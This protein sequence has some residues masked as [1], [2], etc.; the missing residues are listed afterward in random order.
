MNRMN[1]EIKQVNYLD[2]ELEIGPG[3]GRKF[4]VTVIRSPAGE[5]QET[6]NFPFDHL[7]LENRLKDLQIALLRSGGKHRRLNLPEQQTVQDFGKDLFKAL[8]CGETRSRYDVS[9]NKAIQQGKGLRLKIRVQSP[10]LTA[11]PWEYIFDERQGEYLCLSRKTPVVRYIE[12]PQAIQ[13]ID[14]KLP[15]RILGM[16]SSPID[17]PSLDVEREKQRIEQAIINLRKKGLVELTWLQGQTWRELQGAMR[18]GP[19]HI[20]HFIGHGGFDIERDEGIICL[21]DEKGKRD[22]MSA[23]QLGRLLADHDSLRLVLLN[24]C[25]GARSGDRDIFSSSASILVQRGIPAVI[26]MQY[27]V[28]DRAAIEFARSFY[29]ALTDGLPIDASVAEAR[30]AISLAVDNTLE[31]GTPVLYMRSPDGVLFSLANKPEEKKLDPEIKKEPPKAPIPKEE[32]PLLNISDSKEAPQDQKI[33]RE[34]GKRPLRLKWVLL[35]ASIVAVV[36]LAISFKDYFMGKPFENPDKVEEKKPT[37]KNKLI[38]EENVSDEKNSLD[39]KI[40]IDEKMPADVRALLE[41]KKSQVKK[42][43]KNEKG[44][45][46]A[47]FGDGII[48]VYIPAGKFTMGANDGNSAEKPVREV[49]VDGYW[50]GKY[51]VTFA[52]YD[53]FCNLTEKRKPD[54]KGWSRGKRPVIHVNWND[55]SEYCEWLSQKTGLE[56]KLPTEAQWEKAARGKYGRKYPWG[57][58]P[59]TGKELNFADKQEWLKEKDHFAARDID[60]GFAY[61]APVDSFPSGSSPYGLMDMVGNVWEW[62]LDWYKEDFYNEG[63]D[64]NPQGPVKGSHRVIRGGSWGNSAASCR[65]SHRRGRLPVDRWRR[66][67]FRLA[68]S[69]KPLITLPL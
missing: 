51:E 15:L 18:H 45:W 43:H 25:E 32:S 9:L 47:D 56:F 37:D 11:L 26:A 68:G 52:Q 42:V 10:E 55:A 64:G 66:I 27:E 44:F 54:D 30:K 33:A 22:H 31:W 58:S 63:V 2:Y 6:M 50:I 16:I 12:L 28:T 53:E 1:D 39:K 60:D 49:Y 8:I 38:G 24:S 17:L 21:S 35:A 61:T 29:E 48:M 36:A 5:A 41:N 13:P 46:E 20:F 65:A 19:W 3:E 69:L 4:P 23:S 7:A 59:P 40:P 62:C 34:K 57:N 14:V 67:G